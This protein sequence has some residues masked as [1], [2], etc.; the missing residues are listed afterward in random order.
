MPIPIS[1]ATGRARTRGA[2]AQ[3][4][5]P[6]PS[7]WLDATYD[8]RIVATLTN[9]QSRSLYDR[10]VD[11]TVPAGA[12]IDANSLRAVEIT[13]LGTVDRAYD[14]R[15]ALGT[16]SPNKLPFLPV[17]I[18]GTTVTVKVLGKWAASETRYIALYWASTG[19][20][21]AL[22]Y[23]HM[24][25]IAQAWT[26]TP[27]IG[28]TGDSYVAVIISNGSTL[29]ATYVE[30][31]GDTT[32]THL[33]TGIKAA[34]NALGF[35][36]IATGTS[37]VTITQPTATDVA[38]NVV[39]TGSTQP[40][41]VV[42]AKPVYFG[43]G[44]VGP[45]TDL[46]TTAS[47][48]VAGLP[49]GTSGS[50]TKPGFGRVA[51]EGV[52]SMT[53]QV[54]G[55]GSKNF[56]GATVS[57]ITN[58]G[59]SLV[60]TGTLTDSFG[61]W[62]GTY[63]AT[64]HTKIVAGRKSDVYPDDGAITLNKLVNCWRIVLTYTCLVAHA[65]IAV[66]AGATGNTS[67]DVITLVNSDNVFSSN[68][69]EN[70][71]GTPQTT[72]TQTQNAIANFYSDVASGVIT[73]FTTTGANTALA[74][75]TVN[76]SIF[77]S[78]GNIVGTGLLINS[79]ALS[80]F[81][82]Q[83]PTL[84]WQA[85]V[86]SFPRLQIR[87]LTTS[88][89]IPVNA[90][91]DL[92]FWYVIGSTSNGTSGGDNLLP[93]EVVK[94]LQGLAGAAPTVSVATK[95]TYVAGLT[96]TMALAGSR[97][98]EAINWFQTNAVAK[99]TVAGNGGYDWNVQTSTVSMVDDEDSNYGEAYKLAGLCLRYLRTHDSALVASIE[100]QA[101][102]H[103]NIEQAAIAAYGS[104]WSGST[105]YF[106]WPSVTASSGLSTEGGVQGGGTTGVDCDPTFNGG[107]KA[108]IN[109]TQGQV[110]RNTSIDQM[111]MVALGLY[112]YY[113]LLRNETAITA[114]T[115]LRANVLSL[116]S[117][118]VTFEAAHWTSA[119]SRLVAN[120][121][122]ICQSLTPNNNV[123]LTDVNVA[124]P[125]N[126][127]EFGP[128]QVSDGNA[129]SANPSANISLDSFINAVCAPDSLLSSTTRY[130]QGRTKDM[131][132]ADF[133]RHDVVAG[134]ATWNTSETIFTYP[135]GWVP[136]AAGGTTYNFTNGRAGDDH[137]LTVSS[138]YRDSLN[139]RA[140]Q[141]MIVIA[142]TA[143]LDPAYLVP[144]ELTG[145]TT[146]VREVN[147]VTAFDA[148]ALTLAQYLPE[149]TIKAIRYA[150]VGKMGETSSFDPQRVDS[151][152]TGYWMMALELWHLVKLL[153]QGRF[154]TSDYYPIGLW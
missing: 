106:Y 49:F 58:N 66:A 69:T 5:A 20:I 16:A 6:I 90:T 115:T 42:V 153:Q 112:H 61:K 83:S 84:F 100:A 126:G 26:L 124:T 89:N 14:W 96:T 152:Y 120:L 82:G 117:R 7:Y 32:A 19:G 92:D 93:D 98:V 146:V 129:I 86:T 30:Q 139:G 77:G 118:M 34:I 38:F 131:M 147:I 35:G 80:G 121:Y 143:L 99:T 113:Y 68:V 18:S 109:Y 1:L 59:H 135:G 151:A 111:H 29:T 75:L 123:G 12:A 122:R 62:G 28:V 8:R 47:T 3:A 114:N 95:E 43:V 65:P 57:T 125:Y 53:Y 105:P 138:G 33:T 67:T 55:V 60:V 76:G 91:I 133:G 87:N 45:D 39:N 15:Y 134:T 13:N 24:G 148:M 130:M 72:G 4:G 46:F 149:P 103:I 141:R 85:D 94:I 9:S 21:A 73:A 136:R 79:A 144:I 23:V 102:Y 140:G 11:I 71:A 70:G 51:N 50:M 145:G 110:R 116:I 81:T 137:F 36:T 10:L 107:V 31:A 25:G 74:A 40:S 108:T 104:Y 37:S 56:D 44:R 27:T 127:S 22:N 132:A 88:P 142:L 78:H 2:L 119:T 17:T 48:Y 54:N 101:Q 154:V 52:R 64:L 41:K 128:W 97:N 63:T 150:V